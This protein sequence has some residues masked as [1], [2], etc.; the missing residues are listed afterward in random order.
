M[1]STINYYV[2]VA[3]G[4]QLLDTK[5]QLL[6][7]IFLLSINSM[8]L[9][10]NNSNYIIKNIQPTSTNGT[11]FNTYLSKIFYCSALYILSLKFHYVSLSI[12]DD[13][14]IN[15]YS[16]THRHNGNIQNFFLLAVCWIVSQPTFLKLIQNDIHFEACCNWIV[17]S[18]ANNVGNE[19][20]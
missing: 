10:F 5:R 2:F 16:S 17:Y 13:F 4:R 7:V 12:H 9:Y 1:L 11:N 8:E 18:R 20:I 19:I 14:L 15:Q 6:A 3:A